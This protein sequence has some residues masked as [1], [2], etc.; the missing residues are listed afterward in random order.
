M[1]SYCKAFLVV[2]AVTL[3]LMI[4]IPAVAQG[5]ADLTVAD[6]T[7][8]APTATPAAAP[9]ANP[10]PQLGGASTYGD[11]WRVGISIYGWFPATHGTVGVLGHDASANASFSDIF[12]PSKE[13]F[14]LR[15]R[16]IRAAS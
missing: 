13:S 12:L 11:S 16:P 10:V 6:P 15:L 14:R 4:C 8:A 1:N 9:P 5:P 3:T 2:V 7:A